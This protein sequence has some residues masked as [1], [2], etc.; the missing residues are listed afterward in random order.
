MTPSARR[1]A[2]ANAAAASRLA[3]PQIVQPPSET[4]VI[5]LSTEAHMPVDPAEN[6]A[7]RSLAKGLSL[8]YDIPVVRIPDLHAALSD[9]TRRVGSRAV[10]DWFHTHF[11][12]ADI[13][14]REVYPEWRFNHQVEPDGQSGFSTAGRNSFLCLYAKLGHESL[15][16][17]VSTVRWVGETGEMT[18]FPRRGSRGQQ[19]LCSRAGM[20]TSGSLARTRRG[21]A[22]PLS[23]R[24]ASL[25]RL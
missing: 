21:R 23:R 25:P 10:L 18:F 9:G 16:D 19:D 12:G 1:A 3:F 15:W 22:L 24:P 4:A 8:P 2:S 17:E 11:A 6:N 7:W 5:G 20:A 14:P 13:D